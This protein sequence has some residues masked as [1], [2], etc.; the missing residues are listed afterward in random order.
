M[1]VGLRVRTAALVIALVAVG[2]TAYALFSLERER[3][4][5]EQSLRSNLMATLNAFAIPCAMAIANDRVDTLDNLVAAVAERADELGLLEITVVDHTG[6]VL[7]DSR[8]ERFG[9][10]LTD[11][12][13]LQ[14]L[15]SDV[16][17]WQVDGSRALAS[18]PVISGLR[19]G[20]LRAALTLDAMHARLAQRQRDLGLLFVAGALTIAL[21]LMLTLGVLVVNPVSAL[22]AT[23]QRLGQGDRSARIGRYRRDELGELGRAF[24]EMAARIAS[25]TDDL[26]RTVAE[27]T[28][29]LGATNSQLSETNARLE[30]ANR[31]L[32]RLAVTDGLTTL[33][34]HRHFQ[35]L[36]GLEL[37]RGTRAP[38]HFAVIM[39][40]VDHFK[41]YNDTHGHP[42]G[43]E[44][45]RQLG[46][47]LGQNLRETDV[48]ARYGG[49]EFVVMLV[50]SDRAAG[51]ATAEKI[52]ALVAQHPFAFREQQ[53]GGAVT[54][55]VGVA[56]YPDDGLTPGDLIFAADQVLYAS[57]RAGRNQVTAT[58]ASRTRNLPQN[59]GA[60]S[61]QDPDGEG[62]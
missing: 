15:H 12:F 4:V 14:A 47:L 33:Y 32:E 5:L 38:H 51:L 49:E 48:V 8:V 28:A 45:L 57:K 7:A 41:H 26:E 54:I 9:E 11:A 59:D 46:R 23:A 60:A 3:T 13:T 36:L 17:V 31:Q 34:N 6:R 1:F 58:D 2:G 43:D 37:K 19:W 20:T 21:V 16:P 10:N 50:D 29:Q 22:A 27:R 52:R 25:H 40:D 39:I 24:D 62:A 44:V 30:A 18:H 55:S 53:P 61:A 56:F 35:E 42:A